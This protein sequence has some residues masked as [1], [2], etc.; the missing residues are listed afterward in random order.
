MYTRPIEF[1]Q[2]VIDWAIEDPALLSLRGKTQFAHTL[3]PMT[4]RTQVILEYLNYGF[5]ALG[6]FLVWI[7]RRFVQFR[8]RTSYIRILSEVKA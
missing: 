1:L 3:H 4:A 6:L 5:A 7:W 2:N 8:D